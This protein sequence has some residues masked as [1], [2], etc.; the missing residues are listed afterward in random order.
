MTDD[1]SNE[2]RTREDELREIP[3]RTADRSSWPRNLRTVG[4]GEIDRLGVDETGRLY[5]DGKAIEIKEFKLRRPERIIAILALLA[6]LAVAVTD[7]W[8]WG[9]E[10]AWVS[11]HYC[12]IN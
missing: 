3:F 12:P 9:C 2:K 10:I 11:G 8:E 7:V 1:S 4:M 6:A 5:W